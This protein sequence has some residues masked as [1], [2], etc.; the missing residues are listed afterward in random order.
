MF[1]VLRNVCWRR[2]VCTRHP[3]PTPRV[4]F[5]P[6]PTGFLHLGGLR[7]ALYNYLFA[8]Q[9][10]GAFILRLED[11]DQ[12]RLI[13]GA[14]DDIE[15][16]LEWAGIPPDESCRRGGDYGPY[17][18]SER[19]QLYSQAASALLQTGH[20]YYCF[21]SNQRLD[22]LKREAQ[23]SGQVPRYDN[24]CRELPPEQVQQKLAQGVPCVIRFKLDSGAEVFQDLV[25]SWTRH[26]PAAAEGDPVILK[27]DGFPTY[28]LASVVD[29]HAM[30]VSHVLRG[31]EWLI[32]TAK[33]LQLFRALR[34][35]PPAYA[36]LPLLLN[37]DGTKL[38][39]RQGDI[40]VQ[41]FREQGVLPETLLDIVTHAGSGFSDNRIGRRLDELV[42]EFNISKITTHSALLDLDKLDEFSRV[43]LQH[44]I[45]DEE[46]C[47]VLRDELRQQVLHTHGSR[48]SDRTV[49]EPH[50]MQRVLQL[51]K[52]HVCSLRELLNDTHT[53]LWI[54]PRVTRQQLQE[55][56]AEVDDIAA[57]VIQLVA[58]GGSFES[59]EHLNTEL[60]FIASRLKHT[61]YSGA[62]RVLRLALSAQQH[63]PSVA[64]MMLSLGEQEV[65][66]RLQK[67]LEH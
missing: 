23:R 57:A 25:F 62:M 29:D 14:A 7:T 16:M 40:F 3:A 24:R 30:R 12:S 5:A 44:R 35:T 9:H 36:H 66:V 64:E 51:R 61:K 47:A 50:Y 38:S 60:R 6:S 37:R 46:R 17:V 27:A 58:S 4:R 2:G 49:L 65:C 42:C 21:C 45:E 54:R 39:K 15:D 11:T 33:H 19:L 32:S 8:K 13:P 10:G 48:I 18:Q 59:T 55:V 56:S 52:G 43:H 28:H 34:W 20:A 1:G 41:R 53:Y 31:S 26:N 22:L 67:A 63:G